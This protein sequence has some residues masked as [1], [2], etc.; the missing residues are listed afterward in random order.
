L[1]RGYRAQPH[2]ATQPHA[3]LLRA[4]VARGLLGLRPARPRRR[5]TVRRRRYP[6]PV[7]LLGRQARLAHAV[8]IPPEPHRPA[9]LP[10][11]HRDEVDR[12]VVVA[13]RD[14]PA[15]PV[16]AARCD[17]GAVHD[18]LGDLPPLLVAQP[19]VLLGQAQRAVPD[20]LCGTSWRRVRQ[21]RVQLRREG[22]DVV[23]VLC[24]GRFQRGQR[25]G[26]VAV[27]RGDQVRVGVLVV[28]AGALAWIRGRDF[29][30]I[31]VPRGLRV[32]NRNCS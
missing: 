9:V 25:R 31:F 15:G 1:S 26:G 3:R 28:P 13:D 21:W 18:V 10:G 32:G 7:A 12:N 19:L 17:A 14:P 27:P 22:P 29:G 8:V 4:A 23:P 5:R 16:I 6:Q 20:V 24:Q 11:E 2:P 30:L